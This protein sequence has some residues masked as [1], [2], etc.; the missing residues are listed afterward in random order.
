MVPVISMVPH[1]TLELIFQNMSNFILFCIIYQY[2]N[3]GAL[4]HNLD[5]EVLLDR[6]QQESL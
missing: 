5:L 4:D 1:R 6:A 2:F 3:L